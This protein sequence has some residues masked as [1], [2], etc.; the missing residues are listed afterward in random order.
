MGA[1]ILEVSFENPLRLSVSF[2]RR[3]AVC[4]LVNGCSNESRVPLVRA[5]SGHGRRLTRSRPSGSLAPQRRAAGPANSLRSNSRTGHP[6][7]PLQRRG[8]HEIGDDRTLSRLGGQC[9]VE[10]RQ[11]ATVLPNR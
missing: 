3:C 4:V 6:R 1:M 11:I 7:P 10:S 9:R 8:G 2:D 5:G